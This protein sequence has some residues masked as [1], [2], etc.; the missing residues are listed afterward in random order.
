M[1]VALAVGAL[2]LL[3]LAGCS[4]PADGGEEGTA[5]AGSSPAPEAEVV[6][7]SLTAAESSTD[8][9][10]PLKAGHGRLA[11]A[12]SM[13]QPVPDSQLTMA[14]RGPEGSEAEGET[15]PFLF[16]FPGTRPTVSFADPAEG[17]WVAHI[18]LSGAAADFRLDWCADE[19]DNAGPAENAACHRY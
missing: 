3:L 10:I 15:A 18:E 2:L 1:R 13:V 6:T 4:S 17:A 11:V 8:I 5:L 9:Q 14:V 16:V 12:L 19:P 7:G